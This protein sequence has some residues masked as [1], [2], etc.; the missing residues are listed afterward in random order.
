MFGFGK[1]QATASARHILVQ[2]KGTCERLKAEI[3]AG[4]DF[5][6]LAKQHSACP[7]GQRGGDMGSFGRGRMVKAFDDVVFE[8]ALNQVHG[9]VQTQ[10]GYH[11][12]EITDRNAAR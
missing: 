1:K 10:F 8:A 4:A 9:P 5:A 2:D 3:E 12:I 7:S 11:L 6:E